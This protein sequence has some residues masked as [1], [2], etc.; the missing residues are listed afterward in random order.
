MPSDLFGDIGRARFSLGNRKRYTVPLS[1]MA[2]VAAIVPIVLVPLLATDTL[3]VLR[4]IDAYVTAPPTPPEPPRPPVRHEDIK[5]RP[6]PDAAPTEA[7]NAI[8]PEPAIEL[9]P[10]DPVSPGVDGGI[11]PGGE[12]PVVAEPVAPPLPPPASSAPVRPGGHVKQPE[13]L[14]YIAPLYP[15]I[16]QAARVQ[17]TVILE[18]IIDAEGRIDNLRVLRSIPLLDQA[19]IDAVRQWRY[20]PTL[21]N[22]TPVSV[23]MTVTV[24]FNLTK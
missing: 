9:T 10:S 16:A 17:G 22:N 21:L 1:L 3:P 19:A 13:R 20:S 23:I 2:H 4:D 11:F 24:T 12:K 14:Q 5:P 8:T 6:N 15:A 18:A 7:P